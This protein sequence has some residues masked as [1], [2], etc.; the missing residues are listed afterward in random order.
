MPSSRPPDG[1]TR[2][3]KD[4]TVSFRGVPVSEEIIF[5]AH[6]RRGAFIGLHRGPLALEVTPA[7]AGDPDA[8]HV[9]L[10]DGPLRIEASGHPL[11]A[12]RDVFD[13]FAGRLS[14][15]YGERR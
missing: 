15:T 2:P 3:A 10:S 9:V 7:R 13:A 4:L 5:Y 8:I 6:R 11:L 14:A 1:G 12:V